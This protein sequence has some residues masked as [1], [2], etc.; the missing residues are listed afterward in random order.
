[1]LLVAGI[2]GGIEI[3]GNFPHVGAESATVIGITRDFVSKVIEN[4]HA[5]TA[6]RIEIL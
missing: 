2:A 3:R 1:M 6:D 5:D 4:S